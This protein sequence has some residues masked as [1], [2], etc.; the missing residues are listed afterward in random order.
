MGCEFRAMSGERT[1][2]LRLL[3]QDMQIDF[4]CRYYYNFRAWTLAYDY[5]RETRQGRRVIKRYVFIA[6]PRLFSL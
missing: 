5:V 6:E 4:Y 2:K 1:R 3:A